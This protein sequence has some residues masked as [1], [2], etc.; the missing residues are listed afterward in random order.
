MTD[1]QI[2]DIDAMLDLTRAFLCNVK[3]RSLRKRIW[4]KSLNAI[5]RSLVDIT[6]RVV[7][8]VRSSKLANLLDGIVQR[9]EKD[10]ENTFMKRALRAGAVLAERFARFAY[11]WGYVGAISW[12]KD[13]GYVLYLG[14]SH[15]KSPSIFG[16]VY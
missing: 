4:Y 14:I 5:E 13:R 7:D 1:V 6:M 9:L 16:C 10:L 8:K 2:S 11:S 15:M 12:I 3:A